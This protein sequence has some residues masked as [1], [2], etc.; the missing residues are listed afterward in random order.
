MSFFLPLP[1][2]SIMHFDADSLEK[3]RDGMVQQAAFMREFGAFISEESTGCMYSFGAR[4]L[5]WK[6]FLAAR[7]ARGLR[8][9]APTNTLPASTTRGISASLAAVGAAGGDNHNAIELD[10]I[11]AG[12]ANTNSEVAEAAEPE[13]EDTD[14]APSITTERI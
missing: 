1:F 3:I 7:I 5:H 13:E 12:R 14:P 4:L 9:A 10:R 8:G 2:F 11:E 6:T